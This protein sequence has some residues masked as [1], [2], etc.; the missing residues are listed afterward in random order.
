M[1]YKSQV[2]NLFYTLTIIVM[3]LVFLEVLEQGDW[4]PKT[5]GY[6]FLRLIDQEREKKKRKRQ[7]H[8]E[9]NVLDEQGI[10]QH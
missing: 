2:S 5:K 7:N 8:A 4:K 1:I 9:R 6:D 3:T 10:G